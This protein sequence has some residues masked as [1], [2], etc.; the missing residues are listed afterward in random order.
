[1]RYS[2]ERPVQI[3]LWVLEVTAEVWA[4]NVE[5]DRY[6]WLIDYN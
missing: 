3:W 2:H 6:H 1:M 4:E 5:L